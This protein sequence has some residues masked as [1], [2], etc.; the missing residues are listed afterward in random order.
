MPSLD[1][2]PVHSSPSAESNAIYEDSASSEGLPT[3]L[4]VPSRNLHF[5]DHSADAPLS[6]DIPNKTVPP[7][8]GTPFITDSASL[9]EYPFPPSSS[10]PPLSTTSSSSSVTSIPG[11]PASVALDKH[12]PH[13]FARLS[14][15]VGSPGHR[16]TSSHGGLSPIPIPP[17]LRK[18][19]GRKVDEST[20]T[21]HDIPTPRFGP[22]P[23]PDNEYPISKGCATEALPSRGT[24]AVAQDRLTETCTDSTSAIGLILP[25]TA[26]ACAETI[27]ISG[28][29]RSMPAVLSDPNQDDTGYA[30]S[31]SN[32]GNTERNVRLGF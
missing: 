8:I 9:F 11:P 6:I 23:C 24:V 22:S 7:L 4:D 1:L 21:E 18:L 27:P 28:R 2:L 15:R 16:R 3:P 29:R 20:P 13:V 31:C 19:S 32:R 10:R 26:G 5:M 12:I 14:N 17:R 25:S 30:P